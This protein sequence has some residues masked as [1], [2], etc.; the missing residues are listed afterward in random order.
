LDWACLLTPLNQKLYEPPPAGDG[1]SLFMFFTG[2]LFL[3]GVLV[4]LAGPTPNYAIQH[5]LSTRSP[6]EA[7]LENMMMALV[8]LAP[9]FLLIAGITVLGLV[10]FTPELSQMGAKVDFEKIL[11]NVVNKY[12][13]IGFKGLILAGLLAA[14]MSTFVS[15]V[16]SGAAYIVN[17]IYRRYLRPNAPAQRYVI[18]G[19]I[20]SAGIILLGIAFGFVTVSVHLVTK[21]IVSALVPAFVAPNV[22]KWHWWRFNGYGFF[23]GMVS[24]TAA[25]ILVPLLIPH[26]HDVTLFLFVLVISFLASVVVCLLTAPESDEV[27]M[28]F[29]R[30]VRPW[31]YWRPIYL[32]LQAANPA[33]QKNQDFRRDLFNLAV[34]LVW[35][36]SMVTLP[37]YLVI[38]QYGRMWLSLLVFVLTSLILKFTWYNKL[39]PGQMY[40][41]DSQ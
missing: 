23:A 25:A 21:W 13:P 9:R 15:T 20:C 39:G 8:S 38:Q 16:N 26:L 3:K 24:G 19:Y 6:R 10:F 1:Y 4:S 32:K 34:G 2:M 30:T 28:S 37:I 36:T 5:V 7:A 22:L 17:D 31:G 12:V 11:P 18:L 29:Y 27:L 14:F 40:M 41:P 33:F 35:Q